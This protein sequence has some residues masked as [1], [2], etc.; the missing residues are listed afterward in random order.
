MYFTQKESERVDWPMCS[1][2]GVATG[3]ILVA[4][5]PEV[6]ALLAFC[7]PML[8][9]VLEGEQRLSRDFMG[10]PGPVMVGPPL[11]RGLRCMPRHNI[12]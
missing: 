5:L 2:I 1:L 9:L 8:P 10:L 7:L 3:S 4:Y 6:A 11:L 12:H